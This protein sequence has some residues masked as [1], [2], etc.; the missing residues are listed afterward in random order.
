MNGYGTDAE[1]ADY[2]EAN[3]LAIPTADAIASVRL[4][5]SLYVDAV[6]G[7]RFP[8]VPSTA[9]QSLAW[10]RR[11]AVDG[12]GNPISET[13]I[14]AR[15]L[16]ACYE[17]AIAE[18]GSPGMLAPT[19]ATGDRIKREKVG[20]IEVE[21]ALDTNGGSFSALRPLLAAVEGILAPLMVVRAPAV[22]VV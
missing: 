20:E 1:L 14:P 10:P 19:A 5:G 9:S 8:G 11:G 4:R 15:V 7:P 18:A 21:Y 13:E 6:Y 2:A 3:G 22:L 16:W 12:F 17:A